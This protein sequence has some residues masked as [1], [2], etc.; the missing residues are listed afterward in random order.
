MHNVSP[1]ELSVSSTFNRLLAVRYRTDLASSTDNWTD[2]NLNTFFGF[3]DAFNSN[4][5]GANQDHPQVYVTSWHHSMWPNEC[6]HL[7]A[8]CG[9][10]FRPNDY[11]MWDDKNVNLIDIDAPAIDGGIDPSW[12]YG[13]AT[14]PHITVGAMCGMCTRPGKYQRDCAINWPDRC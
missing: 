3:N 9:G 11:Y 14:N 7:R 2:P 10:T 13:S 1:D 8:L 4:N 6:G 5:G 12:D